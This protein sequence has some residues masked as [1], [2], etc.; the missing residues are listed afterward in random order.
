MEN[1]CWNTELISNLFSREDIDANLDIPLTLINSIS[2]AKNNQ[3]SVIT[4][5]IHRISS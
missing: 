4:S 1:R 3:S 2:P 5:I